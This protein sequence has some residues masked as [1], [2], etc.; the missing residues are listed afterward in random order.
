MKSPLSC[1][2]FLVAC[3]L[4]GCSSAAQAVNSSTTSQMPNLVSTSCEATL[5]TKQCYERADGIVLGFHVC[6]PQDSD[7]IGIFPATFVEEAGHMQEATLWLWTCGSQD[8]ENENEEGAETGVIVF[9]P[10]YPRGRG[11]IWPLIP[12]SYIAVLFSRQHGG[13]YK[14]IAKSE[15]FEI[16]PLGVSCNY[17]TPSALEPSMCQS[18]VS[19]HK[20][21]FPEGNNIHAAFENCDSFPDDWIGVVPVVDDDVQ[22]VHVEEPMLWLYLCGTQYCQ[23]QIQ[24]NSVVFRAG[25]AGYPKTG[26]MEFYPPLRQGRYTMVL[27]RDN[28]EGPPYTVVAT[29]AVFEVVPFG[30]ICPD[31]RIVVVRTNSRVSLFGNVGSNEPQAL[32]GKIHF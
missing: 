24:S 14:S 10:H 11:G 3:H 20:S 13:S 22:P 17:K 4:M 9:G 21:C 26:G 29:S 23:K 15:V 32:R 16:L 31:E 12:D 30:Q 25:G 19:V 6:H 5:E 7:W 18:E 8:C 2:L 1:V 28:P 27:G